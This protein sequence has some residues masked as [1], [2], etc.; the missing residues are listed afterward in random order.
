MAYIKPIT[1]Y[2]KEGKKC[3]IIDIYPE[4]GNHYE[5]AR[6]WYKFTRKLEKSEYAYY[7]EIT[8]NEFQKLRQE[9]R[10]ILHKDTIDRAYWRLD[11]TASDILLEDLIEESEQKSNVLDEALEML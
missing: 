3:Y 11:I 6:S 7:F 2:A 8:Q 1:T 4:E 5:Y 9:Q 10:S